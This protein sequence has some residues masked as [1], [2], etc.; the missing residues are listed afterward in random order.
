MH[1]VRLWIEGAPQPFDMRYKDGD[2]ARTIAEGIRDTPYHQPDKNASLLALT[3]DYGQAV[4]TLRVHVRA[5]QLID[6]VR[7]M[8]AQGEIGLLTAREQ[9][10]LQTRAQ[11]DQT[12]LLHGRA[13][14]LVQA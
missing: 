10:R 13:S 11:T 4:S 14:R 3:D 8:E 6:V 7:D 1:I 5:S 2:I 9:A 12:L